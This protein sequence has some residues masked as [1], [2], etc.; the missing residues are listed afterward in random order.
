M[1]VII[2]VNRN[3]IASNLKH[4]RREP[5]IIVRRDRKR[6]YGNS[7]EIIGPARMVYRP[8]DPLDCGARVWIE[9]EDAHISQ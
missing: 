6:E 3:T 1:P 9:A 4:N 5:P 2:H 8:D 7:V